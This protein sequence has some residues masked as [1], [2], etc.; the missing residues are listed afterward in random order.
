MATWYVQKHGVRQL[1]FGSL[2]GEAKIWNYEDSSIAGHYKLG[3]WQA[4]HMAKLWSIL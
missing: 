2:K 4:E 3:T 1:L